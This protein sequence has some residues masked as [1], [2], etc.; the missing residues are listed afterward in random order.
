MSIV[1][2][3]VFVIAGLCRMIPQSGQLLKNIR[4]VFIVD[5]GDSQR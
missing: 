3:N 2:R 4:R 5:I 1:I